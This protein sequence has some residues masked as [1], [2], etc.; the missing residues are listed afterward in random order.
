MLLCCLR[1]VEG[2]RAREK[3]EG[4]E[5]A[6]DRARLVERMEAMEAA[7][8]AALEDKTARLSELMF[9]L[10]QA[11]PRK[12]AEG[13]VE[14]LHA[15]VARLQA[16]T[17]ALET[18]NLETEAQMRELRC[19]LEGQ[20][21]LASTLHERQ[22]AQLEALAAAQVCDTCQ[23]TTATATAAAAAAAAAAA[24]TS[25][26]TGTCTSE[27]VIPPQHLQKSPMMCEKSPAEV[28]ARSRSTTTCTARL[29]SAKSR[30]FG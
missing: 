10:S 15:E 17:N 24:S 1:D 20:R 11:T 27:H 14:A 7:H 19:A 29:R 21:T 23:T 16:L 30:R 25:T 9:E 26:S 13:R 22:A 8:A 3:E 12:R 5:A 6:A 4:K 18:T 2:E 28:A